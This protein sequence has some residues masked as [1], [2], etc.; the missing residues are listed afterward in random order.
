VAIRSAGR[1][2]E[3][4][5]ARRRFTVDEYYRMAEAGILRPDERLELLDGEI[6][7]L[8]PIGY[9]HAFYVDFLADWLMAGTGMRAVVRV[10]NPVRL[11]TG[12]EPEPDLGL[13]RPPPRSRYRTAH[14]GPEDV[15]LLIEV[16]DT[17]LAYD[18]E[19]KLPLNAAA[20]IPEAWILDLGGERLLVHRDPQPNG[21][22]EAVVIER[23]GA[24][25]PQSFPDLSL[26]LSE[27]F[28]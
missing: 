7:T 22:R 4:L 26:S 19:R 14:P 27:L 11:N 5:P 15:L 28:G 18:L 21:Y 17:T 20:G 8:S 2:P 1:E 12:A 6:F 10:Q 13:L 23:D 24:A 9:R 3:V 16:S 25:S